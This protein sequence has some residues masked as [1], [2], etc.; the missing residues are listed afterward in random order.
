MNP[1]LNVKYNFT[2]GHYRHYR[3]GNYYAHG[4][5]PHH[6]TRAP[7]VLYRSMDPSSYSPHWNFRPYF[8]V[9]YDPD[10]WTDLI[11]LSGGVSVTRFTFIRD[12]NELPQAM[13]NNLGLSWVA[14]SIDANES[15]QLPR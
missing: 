13:L 2:P 5:I 9:D 1:D 7:Y 14:S 15:Y 4:I 3:G 8:P 12:L 11:L 6:D 10:A